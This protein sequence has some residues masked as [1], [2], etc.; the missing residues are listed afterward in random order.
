MASM[1]P[2]LT[3]WMAVCLLVGCESQ[4]EPIGVWDSNLERLE[5]RRPPKVDPAEILYL[6]LPFTEV[7]KLKAIPEYQTVGVSQFMGEALTEV[8]G[9]L[10]SSLRSAAIAVGAHRV[11][12]ARK[13]LGVQP[14]RGLRLRGGSSPP[15]PPPDLGQSPSAYEW[16]ST[17]YGPQG[18]SR[19]S[20]TLSPTPSA[21]DSIMRGYQIGQYNSAITLSLLSNM[22]SYTYNAEVFEYV[23]VFYRR[24]SPVR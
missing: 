4:P 9:S 11:E 8:P 18:Q 15:P 12:W 24:S 16:E 6:E 19:T 10:R 7:S 2:V 20:G 21:A 3:C 13:S 5:T 23:A 22:E 14:R 1:S 17:T